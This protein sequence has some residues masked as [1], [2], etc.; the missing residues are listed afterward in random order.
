[1]SDTVRFDNEPEHGRRP[2]E[3]VHPHRADPQDTARPDQKWTAW[4]SAP[5]GGRRRRSQDY[6]ARVIRLRATKRI[7][8]DVRGTD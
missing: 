3:G 8:G 7:L 1:M 6:A 5:G 2:E 4:P